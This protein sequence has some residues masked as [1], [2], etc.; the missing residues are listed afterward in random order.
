MN[1]LAESLDAGKGIGPLILALTPADRPKPDE[2]RS[3]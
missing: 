2:S 3:R 1:V